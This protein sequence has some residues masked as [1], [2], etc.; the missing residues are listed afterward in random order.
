[1]VMFKNIRVGYLSLLLMFIVSSASG[2]FLINTNTARAD[3]GDLE[4][5]ING[6]AQKITKDQLLGISWKDRLSFLSPID[7]YDKQT[8]TVYR[9]KGNNLLRQETGGLLTEGGSFIFVP[10]NKPLITEDKSD[11]RGVFRWTI[12]DNTEKSFL[13][14]VQ[15]VLSSG[16]DKCSIDGKSLPENTDIWPTNWVKVI[17]DGDW[18]PDY[19]GKADWAVAPFFWISKDSIGI[20]DTTNP[21][22]KIAEGSIP[23]DNITTALKNS[24]IYSQITSGPR[25]S[26][27]DY[28]KPGDCTEQILITVYSG[29]L[30]PSYGYFVDFKA[31]PTN[32]I[33]TVASYS[34]IGVADSD[35]MLGR[36]LK[37]N[38]YDVINY[39]S[40][41]SGKNQKV[42]IAYAD[43]INDPDN[44][45]VVEP[46]TTPTDGT[47]GSGSETPS[48]E[49]SIDNGFGWIIC[50]L[51]SLIDGFISGTEAVIA[52]KLAVDTGTFDD[53]IETGND[54][55][56]TW[57]VMAR[58]AS[59][60]L[61]VIA[62]FMI[63]STALGFDFVY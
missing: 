51:L 54:L 38:S 11:C 19:F 44:N 12:R 15:P 20:F 6:T 28:W 47:T 34:D 2:L 61:A 39:A 45:P 31:D 42:P 43:Q 8:D 55:R 50:P 33:P 22:T 29:G 36:T 49:S 48:C 23:Y 56:E 4:Y 32:A 26:G 62:L 5:W 63:I 24:G 53:S 60:L 21:A 27:V 13:D 10:E 1:M 58:L 3:D 18:D 35:C 41:P 25:V 52:S 14:I 46:P 17:D 57:T 9:H 59:G 40:S 7:I 16:K 30:A 37:G